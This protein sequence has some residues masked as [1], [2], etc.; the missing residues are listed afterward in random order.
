MPAPRRKF[1][2]IFQRLNCSLTYITNNKSRYSPSHLPPRRPF[3]KE[4]AAA[5]AAAAAMKEQHP[6]IRQ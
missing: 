5:A 2:H 6:W 1:K 4:S 3:A